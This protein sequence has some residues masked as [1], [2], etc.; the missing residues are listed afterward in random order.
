MLHSP[1][2]AQPAQDPNLASTGGSTAKR[3]TGE[4]TNLPDTAPPAGRS[5]H[6][7]SRTS[8]PLPTSHTSHHSQASS[9]KSRPA[10]AQ[11]N[12]MINNLLLVIYECSL[13][14]RP[15]LPICWR[16]ARSC[17]LGNS[18]NNPETK[19]Y[20]IPDLLA[21]IRDDPDRSE[22][23]NRTKSV[24]WKLVETGQNCEL[25]WVRGRRWFGLNT[26]VTKYRSPAIRLIQY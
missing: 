14:C 11:M 4:S 6:R 26:A 22:S 12:I 23:R 13:L 1:Q 21:V 8:S 16:W 10:T 25:E 17:R 5:P 24:K 2:R 7:G 18:Q 9:S 3:D 15:G 20:I 19:E